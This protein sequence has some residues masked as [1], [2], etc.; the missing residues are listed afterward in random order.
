MLSLDLSLQG[1]PELREASIAVQQDNAKTAMA[2]GPPGQCVPLGDMNMHDCPC[3][4]SE[5][6][7]AHPL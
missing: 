6:E 3:F 4:S 1:N 2:P 5:G 7:S